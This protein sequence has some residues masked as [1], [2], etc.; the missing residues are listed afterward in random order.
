MES[1]RLMRHAGHKL[2]RP[3]ITFATSSLVRNE[4]PPFGPV[5]TGCFQQ[6]RKRR[7]HSTRVSITSSALCN[8]NADLKGASHAHFPRLLGKSLPR[9]GSHH[10]VSTCLEDRGPSA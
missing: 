7:A 8:T 1:V 10:L 3:P 2:S 5:G 4:P 9:M 6:A